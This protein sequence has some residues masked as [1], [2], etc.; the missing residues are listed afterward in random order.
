MICNKNNL[1]FFSLSEKKAHTEIGTVALS[2]LALGF[3][4]SKQF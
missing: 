3:N 2:H 4:T 1:I